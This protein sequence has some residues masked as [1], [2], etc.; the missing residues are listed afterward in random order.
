M[1]EV[2]ATVMEALT[3]LLSDEDAA[4]RE[5]AAESLER[6]D[7]YRFLDDLLAAL[8]APDPGVVIRTLYALAE[9][10]HEQALGGIIKVLGH[11]RADL[12]ATA[13]R[14]LGVLRDPRTI[15]PLV[16]MLDDPNPDVRMVAIDS[17]ANFEDRRLTG[18][19]LAQL[20]D[21]N[22]ELREKVVEVLERLGDARATDSLTALLE[23]PDPGVRCRAAT[24]L[25]H[26]EMG[27]ALSG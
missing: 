18:A 3:R 5:A 7:S 13:A 21:S 20:Q 27:E 6:L 26:L 19:L 25:G 8:D 4:V 17:L 9:L 11:A 24:A 14:I 23:D 15:G 2:D 10:R 1:V 16:E 12:R 22:P